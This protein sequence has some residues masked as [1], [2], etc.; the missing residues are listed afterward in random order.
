MK[1]INYL[2]SL[3]IL[4]PALLLAQNTTKTTV[5]SP[6]GSTKRVYYVSTENPDIKHGSY[7]EYFNRKKTMEGAYIDNKRHGE[8]LFYTTKKKVE[9]RGDYENGQKT[10]KWNY[11]YPNTDVILSEIYYT[12]DKQDSLFSYYKSSHLKRANKTFKDGSRIMNI[13]YEDGSPYEI[14]KID[15]DKKWSSSMMYFQ[16][17][18]VH[19]ETIFYKWKPF[20]II[21]CYNENGE[22]L[23]GGSL[24]N[25]TG[26]FI[27]YYLPFD[28]SQ[29]K[30]AFKSYTNLKDSLLDGLSR[31]VNIHGH[32][33]KRGQFSKD[34]RVGLLEY[35]DLYGDYDHEKYYI[36]NKD[37]YLY[38]PSFKDL[39]NYHID[40]SNTRS[41]KQVFPG[42]DYYKVEKIKR[43]D[44]KE[45]KRSGDW[46]FFNK[47]GI[48]QFEG[49]YE[50]G[51]R[52]GKWLY[53][54]PNT[55][56]ISTEIF[57]SANKI[58]SS[59]SY[60]K[61]GQLKKELKNYSDSSG[62]IKTY[63]QDGALHENILRKNYTIDGITQIYFDNG[64]LHRETLYQYSRPKTVISCYN[65]KGHEIDGGS[66]K[67]GNGDFIFHYLSADN[68]MDTLMIKSSVNYQDSYLNGPAIYYGENGMIRGEGNYSKGKE[69][70]LWF[71]YDKSGEL[72]KEYDYSS[73]VK[74]FNPR[75]L[76]RNP[77]SLNDEIMPSF[78]NGERQMW[79]FIHKNMSDL[80][81][82]IENVITGRIV[83]MFVI[84]KT[85]EIMYTE[86]YQG[87]G[88]GYDEKVIELFEFMPRCSPG[89]QKGNPVNAPLKLYIRIKP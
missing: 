52:I 72:T 46:S 74:R 25:G 50:K 35:Y 62:I 77:R 4:L 55:K 42:D 21:S 13:Y 47:N 67:D 23:N 83:I 59:F 51:E 39:S 18:Q 79:E 89:M 82:D 3:V 48:L 28:K 1:S 80:T 14:Y 54:H 34:K 5:K 76:Q 37:V 65:K 12:D 66:L 87:I 64:Q 53:Y 22:E 63:Y 88:G 44:Y 70:S 57:Y 43:G 7:I 16:N 84:S 49:C 61:N 69:S 2:L 15:K 73:S 60:Y 19:R 41:A 71:Y 45:N 68:S 38:N 26:E 11:Y 8:W 36:L 17:G 86:I 30:L 40:Y 32:T 85:G 31:Y 9:I 20:N 81:S 75:Y 6:D 58:D 78:P 33:T 56:T 10:G 27:S 24:K 29:N